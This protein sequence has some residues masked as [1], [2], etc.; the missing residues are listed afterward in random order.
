MQDTLE[1][2]FKLKEVMNSKLKYFF[3]LAFITNSL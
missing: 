1:N 3:I 2:Y